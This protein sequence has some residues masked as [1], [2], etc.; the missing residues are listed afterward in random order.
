[1]KPSKYLI[2]KPHELRTEHDENDIK[3]QKT[4]TP[5]ILNEIMHMNIR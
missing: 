2:L 5:S 1:M 4:V 3:I